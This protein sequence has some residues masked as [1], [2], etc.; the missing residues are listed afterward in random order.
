MFSFASFVECDWVEDVNFSRDQLMHIVIP[1]E[2][3]S[4][5]QVLSKY[6]AGSVM[7]ENLVFFEIF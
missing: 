4:R 2:I 1:G 3:W 6:K 5:A 7:V